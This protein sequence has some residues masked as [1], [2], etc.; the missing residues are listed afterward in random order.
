MGKLRKSLIVILVGVLFFS[1]TN[2]SVFAQDREINSFSTIEDKYELYPIPQSINYDGQEFIMS[3]E[4]NIVY[5]KQIDDYTKKFLE[6]VLK[7]YNKNYF[8]GDE[9]K[10]GMT[11]ILLGTKDSKGI[12]DNYLD[13]N[14][15]IQDQELYS[16]IDPY[17]LSIQDNI[18]TIVGKDT[19]CTFY[20]IATL[21]MIFS[22]FN[23]KKFLN[24]QIEDFAQMEYRGFIEGFYGGWNYQERESLM[25]FARDIKMNN[26]V[27]ASK[28]DLYHTDKWNEQYPAKEIKKIEKL[29]EVGKETKCYYA[30]SVH[31]SGFFRNLDTSNDQA[32][33][34]RYNQLLEKFMQLYNVGVRKFDILNDDFGAGTNEDVV[35]LLNRLTT[36]FIK[37]KNCQPLTY[38]PQGYNK[39]WSGNGSELEALKALDASII[40][41]WTGD[42]VNSPITQETIN[43]VKDK[44]GHNAC[45]W[46]NYPVNE[47]AKA[48]IFLGDISHYA[49][50]NVTGLSGA[51]SNPSRFGQSNKVALF[52][53]ASLFWN[54]TNYQDKGQ[55]IWQNSFKYIQPEV[56]NEYFIIASNVANCPGSSRVANGFPESEYLKKTLENVLTKVNNGN[57]LE[58]DSEIEDLINE[59]ETITIAIKD[60]KTKCLNKELVK[61]LEPWLNSLNDIAIGGK[62][63]INSIIAL[64]KSQIDIAWQ[65]FSIAG[66]ALET[67][68]SYPTVEGETNYAKAGSK[69]LQPF[70]YKMITYVKNNLAPLVDNNSTDFIPSFYAV[71]GGKEQVGDNRSEKIFDGDDSTFGEWNI[72]QKTND[73]YGVD[74]GRVMPVENIKIIQGKNDSDHDYFHKA[75]LEYSIDGKDFIQ[76][77]DQYDDTLIIKKE[78]LNIKAR[79]VRLRLIETGTANK[80]DFWTHIREFKVNQKEVVKERIYTNVESLKEVPLTL[81]QKEY[82]VRDL[83]DL[84]FKPNQY[85]GIKMTQLS[86]ASNIEFINTGLEELSLQVSC[87]GIEWEDVD[88][89]NNKVFRYLRIINQTDKNIT[90]KINK[91]AVT[92][93]NLYINPV[94]CETNLKNGLKEGKWENL[95]DGD[96]SSYAWTNE[97]QKTND[98]I[99][100]DLGATTSL[101]D[102]K[103]ITEDGNPRFYNA[104]IEMSK[105]KQNWITIAT[106][107]NDNSTFEVPYRYVIGN[108]NGEDARYIR[109]LITNN[110]GYYLKLS[111]IEIN[112]TVVENDETK[113]I[114]SSLDGNLNNC[115]DNDIATVFTVRRPT[116]ENDY[117]EY[118]L[119]ENTKLNNFTILQDGQ[120]ITEAK[121]KIRTL[122]GYQELE[123]F[124]RAAQTFDVSKLNKNILAIRLEWQENQLPSIYEIFKET[125]GKDTDDVGKYVD[126]IIL[127]EQAEISN[128]AYL[129]NIAVSGTSDGS[130]ENITDGTDAKWDSDFIKGPNAKENSWVY[131]DLGSD[132]VSI[133]NEITMKYFNKVYPTKYQIQISNDHENWVT[134]K[135]FVKEH[136]GPTYP[137]DNVRFDTP[138]TVRYVRLFF[139]ELN[140]VAAGNGVGLRELEI[141]GYQKSN[142]QLQTVAPIS[143]LTVPLYTAVNDLNLPKLVK[144]NITD[145]N[146]NMQQV[147]VP[148][149]WD[150][151]SY[152]NTVDGICEL[153]GKLDLDPLVSNPDNIS[154]KINIVVGQGKVETNKSALKKILNSVDEIDTSIYTNKTVAALKQA[155]DNALK[156]YQNDKAQQNEVDK[157]VVLVQNNIESLLLKITTQSENLALYKKVFVSGTSD[158]KAEYLVDGDLNTKWD[159]DFIKGVDAKNEAWAVIDLG[160]GTSLVDELIISFHN[161]VY[162]TKYDVL[163]S[164]DQENWTL[165]DTVDK[166]HNGSAYPIDT[167]SFDQI[168]ACRYLKFRFRELNSAAFGNGVGIKEI[169]IQGRKINEETTISNVLPIAP[170]TIKKDLSFE[171]LQAILP[172]LIPVE[173]KIAGVNNVVT[174]L[175]PVKWNL[176]N[177]SSKVINGM[178]GNMGVIENSNHLQ[179]SIEIIIEDEQIDII[180]KGALKEVLEKASQIKNLDQYTIE[181]KERFLLVV[182]QAKNIYD[183]KL[184]SQNI[185]DEITKA[186]GEAIDQLVKKALQKDKLIALITK[187]ENLNEQDYT[188]NSWMNLIEILKEAKNIIK[189][190]DILQE[191]IDKY[192]IELADAIN[193]LIKKEVE[194]IVVKDVSGINTGDN[195]GSEYFI[196]MMFACLVVMYKKKK[197]S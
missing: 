85:V 2:L 167:I 182:E 162:P 77:G 52:Q 35:K 189:Q 144:I 12:V 73:Y 27:Y 31:I 78:D 195:S 42:D 161:L 16:K 49:R 33:E 126:H 106:V 41:Y 44:T 165:I 101:Y 109:I 24:A 92:V 152:D 112:K 97:S 188:N 76:L 185:I 135:D 98:Y 115:I 127:D 184:S 125:A 30:W 79:Y 55:E 110:S 54:S 17:V 107:E 91:L 130:K 169:N 96:Y 104:K 102:V 121:V 154:A 68:D 1:S 38:C 93:S 15:V 122:D 194:E 8:I 18:I 3:D 116:V 90:G 172:K 148:V 140:N 36:E 160:S 59:F 26:Y 174:V 175:M 46:L 99:M 47:H 53:L 131:V 173:A 171:S 20:G 196:L 50:S 7:K 75:V 94:V 4:I 28:T 159:S 129:K 145:A 105:D 153:K 156:V 81:S 150:M 138:I 149:I 183:D 95:F 124:N 56:Q 5:E 181:S 166:E 151:T 82:S 191:Q 83:L 176:D 170:I 39:A 134:I 190:E 146:C 22:S 80:A 48:G 114:I 141:M 132:K 86:V 187:A 21:Q 11:N 108:G 29:V 142:Y 128:I 45:F 163:I 63:I 133:F 34:T 168:I 137:I 192:F 71:L 13:N 157:Q 193:K 58:N 103:I 197:Y 60:F 164:N 158:G 88:V 89:V 64:Q 136:N 123:E 23:G 147:Q 186:L 65:Q 84:T 51:V 43:Y 72:N 119:S 62:A 61:E 180:N 66:K 87:N 14:I 70:V 111:E 143:D 10:E 113:N 25:R 178:I 9:I 69:R 155:Y 179:P 19:D 37:P 67:W 100:I 57:R 74:M 118:R 139:E 120:N 6:E 32:Y 40:I 177:F 117:L